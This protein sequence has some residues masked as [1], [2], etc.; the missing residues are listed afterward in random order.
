MSFQ[1]FQMDEIKALRDEYAAEAR[2]RWGGTTAYSQS[3]ERTKGRTSEEWQEAAKEADGIFRELSAHRNEAPDSPAV[4]HLV[5]RWQ[6]HISRWYYDC[7]NEILAGLG[8]MYQA[9]ERFQKNIDRYGEGLA[10]FLSQAIRSHCST[11]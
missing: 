10:E 6:A 11:C 5:A 8:E 1:E 3:E 2:E 9:D 4:H 7:T